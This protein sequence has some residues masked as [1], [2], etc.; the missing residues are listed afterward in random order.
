MAIAI[1]LILLVLGTVAFHVLNPWWFTPIASNWGTMDDTVNLTF[2]VTGAVFVGVNL[3]M[4]Y[5]IVRYRHRKGVERRAEYEPEYRKLEWWLIGLTSVGV[6]AMLAPGLAVWAK[7]VTVPD[8]ADVVEAVGQQWSWSFRLPGADGVLG[9]V[10]ASLMSVANPFGMDPNDPRGRD[11]VL[12]PDAELHLPLDR[13]VKLLL[14][15]KDV[16]H[17]FTVPEFRVKMDLVPGMVT[18]MWL[19]PTKPGQ[20]EILCEELCGTG[21]FAMRGRVVVDDAAA[22]ATWLA[23]Q[24]TFAQIQARPAGDPVVGATAYAV[25]AACHGA[26]A[27]GNQALNAPKLAGLPGWYLTRQLHNFKQGVRG[28]SPGDAIASQMAAITQPLDAATLDNVVAYVVTL[29]DVATPTTVRGDAEAG[30]SRYTTCGY[31]H[32]ARGQGSWSTN[33]PPL[34]GRSD[35]YLARQL[36]QFRQGHRG[37]HPQDFHGSQMARLSNVVPDGEPTADLLAYL[38]TLR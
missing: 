32:G 26:N 31:C 36:N 21:H 20:Y 11:D 33:A 8:D 19:T 35:W 30:A 1:V 9:A 7:F 6:I 16:L 34:A 25:C 10:D 13:P 17:D 18:F 29:P 38:N 22:Y 24:Q 3:F 12:V 4:A 5:A 27:E 37:R 2:W 28:G 15:S 14:R 23:G